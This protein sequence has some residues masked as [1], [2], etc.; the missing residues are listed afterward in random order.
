MAS[1]YPNPW[2]SIDLIALTTLLST[3]LTTIP[4]QTVSLTLRSLAAIYIRLGRQL[5]HLSRRYFILAF[6]QIRKRVHWALILAFA[7]ANVTWWKRVLI[8]PKGRIQRMVGRQGLWLLLA[9]VKGRFANARPGARTAAT[10][11]PS[12]PGASCSPLE[13]V[14]GKVKVQ[15][16]RLRHLTRTQPEAQ[17]SQRS[18]PTA[19]LSAIPFLRLCKSS[20]QRQRVTL[21]TILQVSSRRLATLA[22]MM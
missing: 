6:P 7:E 5:S 15:L 3:Y 2:I 22:V 20:C 16:Q 17:P 18:H 14:I 13:L 19:S 8:G 4:S 9:L 12:S 11:P 10:V 1:H 21:L